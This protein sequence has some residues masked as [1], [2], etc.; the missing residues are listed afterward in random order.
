[1]RDGK[2]KLA[3]GAHKMGGIALVNNRQIVLFACIK[4]VNKIYQVIR[5]VPS[6]CR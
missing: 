1:M 5:N 2:D 3:I 4:K 6:F